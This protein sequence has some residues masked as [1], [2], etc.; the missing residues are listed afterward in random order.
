MFTA[1]IRQDGSSRFG[2][3]NRWGTFPS[4]SAGWIVSDEEFMEDSE[5]ISLLKLRGSYGVTGNNNIGNYTQYALI[6]NTVNSVFGNDLAPGSAVNSMSNSNLGWETT[7]QFD[8]G[9]DLQ[10]T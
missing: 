1:S 10:Q 8:I 5:N 4:V 3:D 9:L 2:S 6:D 7:K